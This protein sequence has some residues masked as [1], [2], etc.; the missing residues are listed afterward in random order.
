MT[1]TAAKATAEAV[2][3]D[4][5]VRI[6]IDLS[7]EHDIDLLLENILRYAMEITHCDGGTVYT[8]D[9]DYLYFRNMIT[10]SLDVCSSSRD[11]G[12]NLPPVPLGRQHVC[13]CAALDKT[14]IS[15]PDIYRSKAYDFTGAKQYD[16]LNGYRTGSMLVI[17][18]MDDRER[19]IGVLQLINAQDENGEV[20]PFKVED[21]TL[22]FGL[23]SLVAV[24]LNNQRLSQAFSDLLHSFVRTMVDAIGLRTPYNANHTKSMA[25]YAARFIKWLNRQGLEWHFEE[26]T[27]DP[28]LMSVW[29]HD[30]GKLIT[31]L[32]VME[33]TSRLGDR[34]E[35]LSH[36]LTV[37]MLMEE[38]R[39]LR[40]PAQQKAAEEKRNA[41]LAAKE[42]IFAANEP[43]FLTDEER[44]IM[45]GHVTCTA[46]MLSNVNFAGE[47]APVPFW[48]ASHHEL[49][50]GSG[51][52]DGK[53]ADDLPREV[54]LLT[55]LDIYD[56]LTAGDRPY[57]APLSS[58]RAF[59][60]LQEMAD[61][62]NA[63]QDFNVQLYMSA[64]MPGEE[65]TGDD[66]KFA[67]IHMD[68]VAYGPLFEI[69]R[70]NA[71]MIRHARQRFGKEYFWDEE[72][73]KA[74][75]A[76]KFKPYRIHPDGMAAAQEMG[77]KYGV[78]YLLFCNLQEVDTRLKHS[79]FSSHV[80]ADEF[81]AKKL[82]TV[83]NFYLVNTHTGM[84]YEG[85][86]EKDKTGQILSLIGRYGQAA[87]VEN[88]LQCLFEVQAQETV[89]DM[90]AAAKKILL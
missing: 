50:D 49:L 42:V 71:V 25:R 84:V 8:K 70:A 44:K 87:T 35:A 38:L 73:I 66:A 59:S 85:L 51:Y 62:L 82:R 68:C 39:G 23:A 45:E 30:I 47:Y 32:S 34:K 27:I 55:I 4:R 11:G 20:V 77:E 57:K 65:L 7:A 37:A 36:R 12:I 79:L 17:P 33:K 56:A 1:Q 24:C 14:V 52:P 69:E 75:R 54:R 18:M 9:G 74:R 81:R 83:S 86:N 2:G 29:L 89:K 6:M 19:V 53:T 78:K 88:L 31:P 26:D 46:Q 40:D 67:L 58:E 72:K 48:A 10:E 60:I 15:L 63:M 3:L 28:F 21:V 90:C 5:I 61:A 76:G 16:M 13:A 22:I 64:G 41:L 80:N 43:G